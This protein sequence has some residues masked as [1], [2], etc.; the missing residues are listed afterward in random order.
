MAR[1][2]SNENFPA[3][4]V[5]LLRHFGHDG[6]T[7]LEAGNANH[8]VPDPDVLRFATENARAILTLNRQDFM[9]LHRQS[10][11]HAGIVICTFNPDFPDQA[12]KIHATLDTNANLAG[13]LVRINRS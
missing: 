6:L 13:Q 8:G 12:R 5:K 3:A 10:S 4:V 11:D 1:L 9:A 7:S 2:Y